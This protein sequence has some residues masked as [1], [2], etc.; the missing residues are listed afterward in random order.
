M[1]KPDVLVIHPLA[2]SVLEGLGKAATIHRVFDAPDAGAVIAKAAAAIRG[3]AATY[4]KPMDKRFIDSLPKLEIIAGFGVGYDYIDVK[5]A[6]TKGIMVTNTPDVLTEEV[7]DLTL[8]LMLATAREL[9]QADRYL[10]EG[11]WLKDHYRL[12]ASLRGRRVGILGLGRIGKAVARRCE[13]FGLQVAYHGRHRQKGVDYPYYDTLT[14]LARDVDMLVIVAPGGAETKHLVDHAVLE[15]LGRDGILIN[16]SRGSLVDEAALIAALQNKT[17]RAAGLD[18][19]AN[20]PNVPAALIAMDNVVLLPHV[21]S[22]SVK[23][24]TEMGQLVADNLIAWF[25]GKGP[26]TP[27]PEIAK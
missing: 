6:A 21:G 2:P 10:R 1:N 23:T 4:D 9:P 7:A 3:V 19:F 24:R 26:L 5:H 14:A 17:I 13:A 15:A 25:A 12:T 22:A 18:V 11:R 27:V 8:G 16:V 20:E